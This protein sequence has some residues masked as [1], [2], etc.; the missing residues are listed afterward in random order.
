MTTNIDRQGRGSGPVLDIDNLKVTFATDAGVPTRISVVHSASLPSFRSCSTMSPRSA[1]SLSLIKPVET[2]GVP[3]GGTIIGNGS[4]TDSTC[5][6][7]PQFAA[8]SS[9]AAY[10]AAELSEPS[11]ARRTSG[12][13]ALTRRAFFSSLDREVGAVAFM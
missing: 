7:A 13:R 4:I 1:S 9:A 2:I 6:L 8:M 12:E 3:G 11:V 10:A 5:T